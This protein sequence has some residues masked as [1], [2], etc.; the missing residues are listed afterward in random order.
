MSTPARLTT[1]FTCTWHDIATYLVG[2]YLSTYHN[3]L[4]ETGGNMSVDSHMAGYVLIVAG[5]MMMKYSI[6]NAFLS[7]V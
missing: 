1:S 7:P 4:L 5:V 3:T 6:D 2:H